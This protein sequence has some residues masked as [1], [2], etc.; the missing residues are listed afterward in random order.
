[1]ECITEMHFCDKYTEIQKLAILLSKSPPVEKPTSFLLSF[2]A[3]C[4]I[5]QFICCWFLS[6]NDLAHHTKPTMNVSH[7]K[8]QSFPESRICHMAAFPLMVVFIIHLSQ[9]Q[10]VNN[11]WALGQ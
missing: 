9:T 8:V 2:D 6:C 7:S 5:A 3:F 4:T 11:S 10:I 1:M